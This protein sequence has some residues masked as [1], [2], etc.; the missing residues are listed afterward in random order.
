MLKKLSIAVLLALD[1]TTAGHAAEFLLTDSQQG[2]A[3]CGDWKITSEKL[4]IRVPGSLHHREEAPARRPP[5]R[6]DLLIVDN[7]VEDHPGA[8]PRHGDPTG[9]GGICASAYSPVKR[10]GQPT[11]DPLGEPWQPRLADGFNEMT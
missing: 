2:G 3:G 9:Q 7:G 11:F 10:G 4:G 6:V 5:G 8:D 1:S